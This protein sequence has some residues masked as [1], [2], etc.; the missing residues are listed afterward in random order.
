MQLQS[1]QTSN[2]KPIVQESVW[3]EVRINY[4]NELIIQ[5]KDVQSFGEYK[6]LTMFLKTMITLYRMYIQGNKKNKTSSI[7]QKR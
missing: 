2:F 7:F 6:R 4:E 3:T 5:I 1:G